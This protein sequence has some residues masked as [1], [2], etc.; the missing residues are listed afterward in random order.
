MAKKPWKDFLDIQSQ[1]FV[2]DL[3]SSAS[4]VAP[5][6]LADMALHRRQERV[7][8]CGGHD[9]LR[10]IVAY[11]QDNLSYQPDGSPFPVT[12]RADYLALPRELRLNKFGPAYRTDAKF[13]LHKTLADIVVG[14]AIYLYQ[15]QGWTMTLYDGLR[16]VEGAYNLYLYA[17][18]SDMESGLLS[19]PGQ[20]AHNKGM[21]VDSMFYDKAG[22]EVD[23]GAHFD[24]LDMKINSR[25]YEGSSISAAAKKNRKLR[26][27][28]FLRAAF[29]QG[30]L[31]APLRTEFWDDRLP[32]NR[33]D[34]WRVT[35][36]AAR[37]IGKNLLTRDDE[38]L[39]QTDRA[40]FRKKWECWDYAYFLEH[41]KNTFAGHE[42][43]LEDAIG[44]VMPP[45]EEKPEFYHGNYHPIYDLRLRKSGK[46]I[47]LPA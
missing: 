27:A 6:E 14:A 25:L 40:A 24:H 9:P 19:M 4:H 34:L 46:N 18:D 21:A 17:P 10:I 26:E 37:C 1:S 29:A 32:E 15:S 30:R 20:S 33:E 42:L 12:Q 16:T 43:E 7:L 13:W 5:E 8:A 23:M 22:K 3:V 28:A 47:T 38:N 45:A 35:D 11:A 41:W 2:T 31:I 39:R 44:T 36:S